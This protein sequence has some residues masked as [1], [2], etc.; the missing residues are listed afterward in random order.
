MGIPSLPALVETLAE[1]RYQA[2]HLCSPGPSGLAAGLVARASGT[3]IVGSYH[4][5]LAAYTGMRSGDEGLQAQAAAFLGALYGQCRTVLSPSSAADQSLR[6]LGIDA[7][8]IAGWTPGVDLSR[9]DPGRRRRPPAPDELHV[10]YAG[11][12]TVEKGVDLLADAFL[13]ARERDPRLRLLAAGGGPEEPRLR[14]RL[15]DA[16][17]FLGWLEGDELARAYAD[18]DVFLFASRTDTLGQV[19][20][21]AQ[22]SGLAIVA[23]A[24]GGRAR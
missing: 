23:V 7:A 13:A 15:G 17:T 8:R 9:F 20:L 10:L 24:E 11:R 21:E 18:A 22:A 19:I 4:T 3:P 5:E 1:G 6:D 14:E 2:V 16:P 12:L